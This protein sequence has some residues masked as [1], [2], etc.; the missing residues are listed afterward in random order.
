MVELGTLDTGENV[1]SCCLD[2]ESCKS[3]RAERAEV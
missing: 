1:G 2:L 3:H